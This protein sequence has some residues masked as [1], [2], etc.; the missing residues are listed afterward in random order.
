MPPDSAKENTLQ[1]Q[2]QILKDHLSEKPDVGAI[3]PRS[4]VAVH[5][6]DKAYMTTSDK[7]QKNERGDQNMT[8][9]N[10]KDS[11]STSDP[12]R[13]SA[14]S[15]GMD[16]IRNI[17]Q[18]FMQYLH[19]MFSF[20]K[21]LMDKRALCKRLWHIEVVSH[22]LLDRVL[23]PVL[24]LLIAYRDKTVPP[25][26]TKGEDGVGKK[27]KDG[28]EKEHVVRAFISVC[29]TLF[30]QLPTVAFLRCAGYVGLKTCL[31]VDRHVVPLVAKTARLEDKGGKKELSF[32]D[33]VN[34]I[35]LSSIL[36]QLTGYSKQLIEA[37]DPYVP[38]SVRQVKGSVEEHCKRVW[39]VL[40]IFLNISL[41]ANV[42]DSKAKKSF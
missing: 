33:V 32:P 30:V 11:A 8:T 39:N 17:F 19:G 20:V 42:C 10:P 9:T 18:I 35:L 41:P 14:A 13:K 28:E 36:I 15:E 12:S 21:Q 26:S 16:K 27:D 24:P 2:K 29:V 38:A 5:D 4:N 22:R 40:L 31:I 23:P 37:A 1:G 7:S 3:G 25:E 34:L 6:S